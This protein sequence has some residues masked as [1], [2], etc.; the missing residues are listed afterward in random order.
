MRRRRR[1][2]LRG[3][4]PDGV[5]RAVGGQSLQTDPQNEAERRAEEPQRQPGRHADHRHAG[6]QGQRRQH[7]DDAVRQKR[8]E[9]LGPLGE[10]QQ[11]AAQV[12][13][14][15]QQRVGRRHAVV[16][17][18]VPTHHPLP[19]PPPRDRD[20]TPR[21][22][23][24]ERQ[25]DPAGVGGVRQLDGPERARRHAEGLLGEALVEVAVAIAEKPGGD[26]HR[27]HVPRGVR[28]VQIHAHRVPEDAD[29]PRGHA[30][31]GG[32]AAVPG[33][34]GA[35]GVRR[36]LDGRGELEAHLRPERPA[37]ER[38]ELR[39]EERDVAAPHVDRL[40]HVLLQLVPRPVGDQFPRDVR[41]DRAVAGHGEL[42]GQAVGGDGGVADLGVAEGDALPGQAGR[43]ERGEEALDAEELEVLEEGERGVVEEK[44]G[45]GELEDH[46]EETRVGDGDGGGRGDEVGEEAVVVAADGEGERVPHVV[47][48]R[49]QRVYAS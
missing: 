9:S 1:G 20:E 3:D 33:A 29:V 36:D 15:D 7:E 39:G 12:D 23:E 27:V 26:R 25:G 21:D 22:D 2:G 47:D 42:E 10:E 44:Q 38:D 37:R 13:Q 24:E 6:R 18:L 35:R 28:R 49:G 32:G 43:A 17:V 11:P 40:V 4:E 30:V 41:G 34:D 31:A 16:H 14:S 46:P 48:V 19:A 5:E 8:R 45:L